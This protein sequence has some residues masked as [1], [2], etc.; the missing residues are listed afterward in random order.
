MVEQ[1]LRSLPGE[2]DGD[3]VRLGFQASANPTDA[4]TTFDLAPRDLKAEPHKG[5]EAQGQLQVDSP[6]VVECD[7]AG[8][9]DVGLDSKVCFV[10]DGLRPSRRKRRE[11]PPHGW[12]AC[13]SEDEYVENVT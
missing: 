7:D 9:V 5:G 12:G 13:G 3:M 6:W 2:D 10:D 11:P 1:L 4:G 8:I